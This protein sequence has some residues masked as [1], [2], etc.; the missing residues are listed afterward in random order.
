MGSKSK[1]LY[2]C[3][4]C[5]AQFPK[6]QGQCG[7]CGA[8]GTVAEDMVDGGGNPAAEAVAEAKAGKTTKLSAADGTTVDR[9]PT[10]IGEFDR[11][12]GGGIVPGSF[13]L[14]GGE[15]G[16]GKS[17]IVLQIADK[18]KGEVLY[19]SGEETAEQ[20]NMR[21]KRLD[22]NA[23]TI[24]FFGEVAVPKICA[25]IKKTK[26]AL[27]II[28][29]IQTLVHN[30]IDAPMGSVSQIRGCTSLL[31][32]TAKES[33]VPI[34]L[35][36]H[37][38]KDGAVAG[39]KTLEH[40]VDTVLYLE[41]DRFHEHRM[42]RAVKNRFGSTSE[43]GV[44]S[45]GEKGLAGVENPSQLFLS[46]QMEVPG[47]CTTAIIEGTRVMLADVQALVTRTVFGYPQRK[48]SGFDA[49]RLQVLLAVLSRRV[50]IDLG[51]YDVHI[52]VVGGLKLTEPAA[53]LAVCLA[54]I[55]AVKDKA[56][57]KGTLAYGEVG[58]AGEIRPVSQETKRS[59]EAKQLGY[60]NVISR[61]S[62][63]TLVA[64]ASAV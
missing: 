61:K 37:V 34:V 51:S 17:T 6:W 28:D 60:S 53:D 35:I 56:L 29:S 30:G 36:G 54:I 63:T 3:S 26:P 39:P 8:W 52:N 9:I 10:T 48:S 59:K 23:D 22:V 64:A 7:E 2:I 20:V 21:A 25:T 38:T 31:M 14:L 11:V 15:P 4:K 55:S 27:A 24:Q 47:M 57:P 33:G 49:N 16:I 32:H 19:V 45:M 18:V 43:V 58:L 13:M 50:N 5:D 40:L 62:H 46:D 44:F 42:L 12:I 1:T 41:G